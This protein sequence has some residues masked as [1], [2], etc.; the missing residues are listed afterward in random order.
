MSGHRHRTQFCLQFQLLTDAK[1]NAARL[2]S[3]LASTPLRSVIFSP[4]DGAA[5]DA[6]LLQQLIAMTQSQSIAALVEGDIQI[7][8]DLSADGVHLPACDTAARTYAEAR[9]ML[10]KNVIVGADAGGSRHDAM[11]LAE[12]GADYIGFGSQPVGEDE[13]P[14]TELRF[15]LAAW[16]AE[17][18]EIP[19]MALDVETAADVTALCEARVDFVALRLD[20]SMRDAELSE[21]LAALTSARDLVAEAQT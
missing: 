20:A 10:G 5:F 19:V 4:P 15:D 12:A 7:A 16:W 3:A 17:I 21:R 1:L 6:A 11:S 8:R 13:A 9:A 2:S 18:F 14:D